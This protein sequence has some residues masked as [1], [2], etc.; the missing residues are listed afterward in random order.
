MMLILTVAAL[1]LAWP[2]ACGAAE[3]WLESSYG[4]PAARISDLADALH[5]EERTLQRKTRAL[6]GRAPKRLLTDFRLE[7]A[8]RFLRDPGRKISEVAYDCGFASAAS[9]SKLFRQ[10]YGKTPSAWRE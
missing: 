3:R 2:E 8:C 4:D 5:V 7:T 9:F 6:F 1:A 10:R